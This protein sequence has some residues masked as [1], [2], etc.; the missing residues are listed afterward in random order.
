VSATIPLP[1]PR[2]VVEIPIDALVED[3]RQSIVFVQTDPE[4]HH[5]TMRR[6]EVTHRFEKTAYVRSKP[7]A[8]EEQ[9][10]ATDLEQGLSPRSALS[11]NEKVLVSGVLELKAALGDLEARRDRTR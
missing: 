10:P 6:V 1:P 3:G 9:L 11:E 8:K 2:G 5:Y 4:K 7:F